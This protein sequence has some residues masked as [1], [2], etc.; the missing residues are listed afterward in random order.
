M[1]LQEN[2]L[3][4]LGVKITGNVAHYPLHSVTYAPATFEFATSNMHFQEK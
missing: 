3:F 1:H 2:T 4:D